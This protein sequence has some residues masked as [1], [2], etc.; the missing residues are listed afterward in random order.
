M[1]ELE[2]SF[3]DYD[4]NAMSTRSNNRSGDRSW[5]NSFDK[6]SQRIILSTHHTV[7]DQIT[8]KTT[9]P[10]VRKT[11]I[12]KVSKETTLGVRDINKR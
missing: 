8:E 7:L 11:K 2:D 10:V 3:Q 1:N 5:N 9:T 6:P 12:D 4:I